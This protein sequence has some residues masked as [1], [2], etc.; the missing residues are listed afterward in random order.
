MLGKV[1]TYSILQA[2][3]NT[4]TPSHVPRPSETT[5]A[6]TLE[7]GR[8]RLCGESSCACILDLFFFFSVL[9]CQLNS[10]TAPDLTC[11]WRLREM[12]Q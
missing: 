10:T 4:A 1:F 5:G 6:R 7:F 8:S 12:K 11:C 3:L 2:N 9:A